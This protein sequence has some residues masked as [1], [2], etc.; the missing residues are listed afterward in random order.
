MTI[1]I[2]SA[3]LPAKKHASARSMAKMKVIAPKLKAL[4]EQYANDKQQL[5]VKMM[6][7]Y[8]QE[9]I[10][11][12]GGLPIL[13]Q[14][15]CSS[16]SWVLLSA[17]GAAWRWVG[18]RFRTCGA[19]PVVRA[20][21]DL[22]DHRLPAGQAVTAD[23]DLLDPGAGEGDADHA[24]RLFGDVRVLPGGA[25]ALL[26]DRRLHPDLQQWHMDSLLEKE[27]AAAAAKRR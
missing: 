27:A 20:A 24:D 9:K 18:L 14:L 11:P 13:V 2:K 6:E 15:R 4:Q 19:G 26:A 21:G 23:A 7:M 1:I 25:G 22:R 16:L 17:V 12:L 8:K 10:N 3:F 5:Q